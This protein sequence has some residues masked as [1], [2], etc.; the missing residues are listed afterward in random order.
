M[1]SLP[2][3]F[4]SGGRERGAPPGGDGG[5]WSDVYQSL[6]AVLNM[7][8]EQIRGLT[9]TELHYYLRAARKKLE[10]T[11][12]RDPSEDPDDAATR[13]A[14]EAVLGGAL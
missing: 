12:G 9:H 7:P 2:P 6:T 10:L 8:I 14:E 1:P 5:G 13:A 3:N 11:H 4:H